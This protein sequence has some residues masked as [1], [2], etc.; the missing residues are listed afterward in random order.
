MTIVSTM[1]IPRPTPI[2]LLAE[3]PSPGRAVCC[4]VVGTAG[5]VVSI[6]LVRMSEGSA[7]I[8]KVDPIA[9]R[10]VEVELNVVVE[11]VGVEV[12]AVLVGRVGVV[13]TAVLVGMIGIEVT[14]VLVGIVYPPAT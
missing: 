14:A 1:M 5:H 6:V 8:R 4:V 10:G 9:E 13:A 7:E 2:A 12:T 11:V 3:V